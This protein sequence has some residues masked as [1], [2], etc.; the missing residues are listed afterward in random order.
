M[1][2]VNHKTG[3]SVK[4]EFVPKSWSKES[5][6]KGGGFDKSGKKRFEISGSFR[7]QVVL[8]DLMT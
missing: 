1:D 8:K 6:V 4:V 5:F 3:D 7:D 2:A